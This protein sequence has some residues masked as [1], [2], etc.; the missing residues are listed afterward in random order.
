V[1]EAKG[2]KAAAAHQYLICRSATIVNP[3]NIDADA[4]EV[5]QELSKSYRRLTGKD[6]DAP[7]LRLPGGRYTDSPRAELDKQ[8]EFRQITHAS[9]L[10]GAA[11][12][13]LSFE[14][15]KPTDVKFLGGDASF[16][17]MTT[18]VKSFAFHPDFPTGSKAQILR[19]MRLVCTPYA[20]C[21]GYMMLPTS[22][23]IPPVDI[24]PPNSPKG[25]KVVRI[26]VSPQ[27]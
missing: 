7:S 2:D 14:P 19:E 13:S 22:I 17:G 23:E 25:T 21:D 9:K 16:K 26:E 12:F 11:L 5:D 20:G 8:T 24:T 18:S 3:L 15:G 1:L 6:I 27:S 4:S 10:T